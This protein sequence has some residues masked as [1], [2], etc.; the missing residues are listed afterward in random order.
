[1]GHSMNLHL[2][3]L[4]VLA[5]AALLAGCGEYAESPTV[6]RIASLSAEMPELTARAGDDVRNTLRRGL[7]TD[8]EVREQAGLIGASIDQIAIERAA[9][10]PQLSLGVVG[11]LGTAGAGDG[12][13]QLSGEQLVFDFGGTDRAIAAADIDLQAQYQ[14]F[15][16]QVDDNLARVLLTYRK[17]GMLEDVVSVKA[18]QLAAMRD[19]HAS[20]SSRIAIGAQARPDLLE[21]NGRM[22]RAEFDLLDARLEL[23][24]L[25]DELLR[26]AGSD[27]GGGIPDFPGNCRPQSGVTGDHLLAQLEFAAADMALQEARRAVYP[28]ITLNPIGRVDLGTGG[29]STGINLGINAAVFDGGAIPARVNQAANRRAS[30][31]AALNRAERDMQLDAR[32]LDRQ[33]A[34]AREKRAMLQR[35]ITLQSETVDLYRSQYMDL[36]TRQITDLLDAEETLYDRRVELV[37]AQFDQQEF[38]V[39]CARNSGNL[40][41]TLGLTAFQIY[42]YPLDLDLLQN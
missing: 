18:A 37:E 28:G 29:V 34:S 11:G 14:R 15:Q 2:S 3:R 24:E 16:N 41:Q 35:Q 6:T 12:Q 13:V 10:F 42:G 21:V 26:L 8:P 7:L 22:E 9:L 36:G 31:E 32:R 4:V 38:L 23:S 30:A 1:M 19:L 20:I 40:R 27:Q 25:R 33:I 39:A 5:G 17:I